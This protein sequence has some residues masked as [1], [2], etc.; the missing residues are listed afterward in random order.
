MKGGKYVGALAGRASSTTTISNSYI[1]GVIESHVDLAHI[2]GL[3]GLN[4]GG[5]TNCYGNV[6]VRSQSSNATIGGIVGS[7]FAGTLSGCQVTGTITNTGSETFIGGIGGFSQSEIINC[8]SNCLVTAEGVEASVGG[9]ISMNR[10]GEIRESFATGDVVGGE[11]SNSGGLVGQN[12]AGVIRNCYAT[13]HVRTENANLTGGLAGSNIIRGNITNC[14]ALGDVTATSVREIEAANNSVLFYHI[15]GLV[16]INS[17]NSNITT[18]RAEGNVRV[19]GAALFSGGLVGSNRSGGRI[20]DS[21]STGEFNGTL[22]SEEV[23]FLVY[24]AAFGG[25]VGANLGRVTIINSNSSGNMNIQASG[26]ELCPTGGLVGLNRDGASITNAYSSNNIIATGVASTLIIGGLVGANIAR[27]ENCH[28]TGNIEG[29]NARIIAGLVGLNNSRYTITNSYASGNVT[30]SGNISN[31]IHMIGGLVGQN[32]SDLLTNSES[33]IRNCY[34]TGEV[35]AAGRNILAGGLV[36]FNLNVLSNSFFSGDITLDGRNLLAGGLVGLVGSDKGRAGSVRN[37]YTSGAIIMAGANNAAGAL[38]HTILATGSVENCYATGLLVKSEDDATTTGFL[39]G[40]AG[41]SIQNCYWDTEATAQANG[42]EG[43]PIDELIGLNTQEMHELTAISTMWSEND[44]HFGDN[45]QYPTL[46][47]FEARGNVQLQ[48]SILCGQPFDHIQCP[49]IQLSLEN[50]EEIENN[51]LSFGEVDA[52]SSKTIRY[53]LSGQD[54]EN[55]IT[56][57]KSGAGFTITEPEILTFIP[58]EDRTIM[59][60]IT[61]QFN[62]IAP[63]NYTGSISHQSV[64][65]VRNTLLKLSGSGIAHTDL[66]EI[67]VL[68][69]SASSTPVDI[70]ITSNVRWRLSTSPNQIDWVTFTSPNAGSGNGLFSFTYEQNNTNNTRSFDVSLFNSRLVTP[71]TE[72]VVT[73]TVYQLAERDILLGPAPILTGEEGGASI[74]VTA[75]IRWTASTT[76][77]WITVTINENDISFDYTKNDTGLPRSTQIIAQEVTDTGEIVENGVTKSRVITQ[78]IAQEVPN[79]I[80]IGEAPPLIQA[81]SNDPVLIEVA[82]NS[83]WKASRPAAAT[84]ITLTTAKGTTSSNLAFTYQANSSKSSREVT[85]TVDAT[86]AAGNQLLGGASDQV[87]VTQPGLDLMLGAQSSLSQSIQLRPNPVLT[88]LLVQGNGSLRVLVHDVS[89]VLVYSGNFINQGEVNFRLLPRG[90]YIVSV[91]H[92]TGIYT[93][94]ILRR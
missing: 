2:G 66:G 59:K 18:C 23:P 77:D 48:G 87:T 74:T 5:I 38:V 82:A 26:R 81:G 4:A 83:P 60:T 46:R 55:P 45:T 90:V 25:L 22:S 85:I 31:L 40:G 91:Q 12:I 20:Q 43:E 63:R 41:E 54:L 72:P 57:T 10:L 76:A 65:E 70:P 69:A 68:S 93:R 24:S 78:P 1:N 36:G 58:Q 16:G 30:S 49:T 84:W 7:H 15:G 50:N 3:I 17:I 64:G 32:G 21:Y 11:A 29:E 8:S 80:V 39:V 88:T 56:L 75:N 92:Q 42:S 52:G 73:R 79:S 37:S 86:D 9:L 28:A 94:R 71:E 44:W 61:V 89:G 19:T 13:G 33:S 35:N 14:Y 67:P 47:T 53:I 6:T 34:A 51:T 27:I 62:P